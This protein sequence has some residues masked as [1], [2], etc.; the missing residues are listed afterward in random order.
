MSVLLMLAL[1]VALVVLI[2]GVTSRPR[3]RRVPVRVC[4]D[5]ARR[6]VDPRDD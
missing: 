3:E 5:R 2:Y 6:P 4:T 1:A